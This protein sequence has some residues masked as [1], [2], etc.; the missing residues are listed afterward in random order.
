MCIRDSG[1]SVLKSHC[2]KSGA[3]LWYETDGQ[4]LAA[5]RRLFADAPLRAALGAAGPAYVEEYYRWDT[6]LAR[7]CALIDTVAQGPAKEG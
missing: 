6:I 3:G 4:C 5:L 7:L 1:C 2:L